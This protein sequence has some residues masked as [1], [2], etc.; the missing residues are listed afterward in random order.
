M[1][2]AR[3]LARLLAAAGCLFLI[4]AGVCLSIHL[5]NSRYLLRATE[6]IFSGPGDD[7]SKAKA[8]SHLVAL[9][10]ARPVDPDSASVTAKLEHSLPL[11][12]S[13]VTVLREGFAFPNAR[14]F[15]PCGQLVRTIRAVGWLR[16]IPSHKVLMGTGATEH[17]MV[18]LYVDGAY[19]L[20]DP[21]YDFYWTGRDG[22]VA[23]IEDVRSDTAIFAQIFRQEPNYPY[24]LSD[25]RYFNWSRLG[26]PGRWIKGALTAVMGKQWV[27]ALDT[28]MLYDRPWW[29]YTWV[30]LTA[31]LVCLL[32]A[33]VVGARWRTSAGRGARS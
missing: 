6:A 32:L 13:P 21:T 7:E 3:A 25:A 8:L 31:G 18:A 26:T 23:S 5:R 20:F 4:L 14:R 2:P 19:R 33:A 24:R 27:A 28:P 10:G 16:G 17:A 29:G 30:S 22:H 1:S 12:L 11:E 15:G 9:Q